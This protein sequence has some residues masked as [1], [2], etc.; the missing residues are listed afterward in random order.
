[1]IHMESSM[2]KR[3]V[4]SVLI[5]VVMICAVVALRPMIK[6]GGGID[7]D[8]GSVQ[9]AIEHTLTP[10][11]S[12]ASVH[13]YQQ[14]YYRADRRPGSPIFTMLSGF[15]VFWIQKVF[16]NISVNESYRSIQYVNLFFFLMTIFLFALKISRNF[17]KISLYNGAVVSLILLC[18]ALHPLS[19]W[20][21]FAYVEE[22][23]A[24]FF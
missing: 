13:T 4:F 1:M 24:V 16:P 10:N 14:S 17:S 18:F 23:Y 5:L 19:I 15:F 22:I 21:A 11:D 7:Y 2:R 12:L 6:K 20:L 3:W 9:G 8:A